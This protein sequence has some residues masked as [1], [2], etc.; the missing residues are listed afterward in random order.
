MIKSPEEIKKIRA[1]GKILGATVKAL[2]EFIVEGATLKEIDKF[3]R[4]KIKEA[5][6]EPTF[7]GYQ[8]HGAA[9]PFPAAICASLNETVVHGVPN[10]YKIKSGDILKI[11]LGV[12]Y[13]DYIA[14]GAFT[15][16]IGQITADAKKL[17]E[18]T[19]NALTM[20]IK[21]C[22]PNKTVG[23]IGWAINNYVTK[24]G[25]KV[26]KGLT[27]H[28]VGKELHEEPTIFNEGQ[29][30]TGIKLK[31]GMTIA[32]EPMVSA[33][34]PYIL[35]MADDSYITR[36]RSLAAHFEHTVLITETGSEILTK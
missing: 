23:D 11:D 21:E 36:D 28:G 14:D 8:P 22:R 27:G 6:G 15:V 18:T 7:L 34:D 29:K 5:G 25:F 9:R 4:R 16:P 24:S 13:Q 20:A 12:T 1:A 2:K 26:I 10:D 35:Q 32:I 30:N 17:I 31:P 33:G 3:T 19:R